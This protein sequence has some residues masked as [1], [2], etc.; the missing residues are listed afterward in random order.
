VSALDGRKLFVNAYVEDPDRLILV[1]HNHIRKFWSLPGCEVRS[2]EA[3]QIA[4]VRT[5]FSE[6]GVGVK[7]MLPLYEDE[8]G[9]D[10]YVIAYHVAIDGM[11]RTMRDE[12]PVRAMTHEEFLEQTGFPK[13]YGR[14]LAIAKQNQLFCIAVERFR[15]ATK[16]WQL[17]THYVHAVDREQAQNSFLIGE[18]EA[19]RR[20]HLRVIDC[21]LVIGY[22]VE[23]NKGSRLSV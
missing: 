17:E 15:L 1:V 12:A 10:G 5:L 14:M 6:C 21:G 7:Q 23:D 19:I 4:C 11:P 20:K 13:F 8:A 16:Q 3:P 22:K 18:E 2:N 9:T